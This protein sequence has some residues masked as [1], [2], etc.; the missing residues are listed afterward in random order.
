MRTAFALI[1]VLLAAACGDQAPKAAKP[2]AP[3]GPPAIRGLV[4][5][6]DHSPVAG[7]RVR[8]RLPFGAGLTAALE[9]LETTTNPEGRFSLFA[10]RDLEPEID[11][12]PWIDVRADG[13]V[14]RTFQIRSLR[15]GH[16]QNLQIG[17]EYAGT[18]SGRVL[19]EDGGPVADAFVYAIM[20]PVA[21]VA[22]RDQVLSATSDVEGRFRIAGLPAETYDVFAIAEGRVRAFVE[23]QAVTARQ[24]RE[25]PDLVL[26]PGGTIAGVVRTPAGEP[27]KGAKVHVFANPDHRE[28]MLPGRASAATVGGVVATDDEGRFGVTGLPAGPWTVEATKMGYRSVG[29]AE[30]EVEPGTTDLSLTI[31]PIRTVRIEV[32]DKL[33]K[34]PITHFEVV[35]L[36]L[37]DLKDIEGRPLRQD[38]AT[39]DSPAGKW[40]FAVRP[41]APYGLE[42]GAEGYEVHRRGIDPARLEAGEYVKV[43]LT[44][45]R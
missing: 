22:N 4:T 12:P 26:P 33:T 20:P 37:S 2:A 40:S 34:K 19:D 5:A 13:F 41:D 1:T 15:I 8:I 38:R 44:P 11:S 9:G 43:A 16:G 10:E 30:I 14:T 31:D 25:V 27:V 39:V 23:D 24:D 35:V 32:V 28:Y 36:E 3:L 7:A 18:L 21:G 29:A 45:R 6:P 17:L 42:V